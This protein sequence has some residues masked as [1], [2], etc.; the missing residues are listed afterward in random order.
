M[1]IHAI[2]AT[3]MT[4]TRLPGKVLMD[5]AGEPALIRLIERLR[6]S[7]YIQDIVIA[8][9][10]NPEDDVVVET[11]KKAGVGYYRGSEED[12]LL[13]TVEAAEAAE[14]DYIIQVTSDCPLI[15][16]ETVDAVIERMLEHPY[17]DYVGNHLTRTYPL[18]FS[19]EI[20]RTVQLREIEQ[21]TNDPADREH[22]SLYFY[23]HPEQYH[24]SNVEAAHVLRHPEYR[25]TLDTIDD[26]HLIRHVFEALY[27]TNPGF[28]LYDIVRYLERKPGLLQ[29]NSHIKQKKA[30]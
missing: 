30:R 2:V 14:T 21:T 26:Y 1:R 3:R 13:R 7:R 20:F 23:E 12:V 18:G 25:L 28:T 22:V 6:K 29:K 8:T 16:S 10:T 5:L 19:A 15:D 27:P 24:L 9:T 11:A 4:S 17:L